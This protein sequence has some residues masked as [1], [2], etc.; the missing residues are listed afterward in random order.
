MISHEKYGISDCYEGDIKIA[1][2]IFWKLVGNAET[3]F[4]RAFDNKDLKVENLVL[5]TSLNSNVEGGCG[6]DG[7]PKCWNF[8]VTIPPCKN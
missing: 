6:V 7:K 5:L 8:T 4:N 2:K 1:E 3:K